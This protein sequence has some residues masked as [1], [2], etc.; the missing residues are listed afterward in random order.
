MLSSVQQSLDQWHAVVV[1]IRQI[2]LAWISV[3]LFVIELIDEKV[4]GSFGF[5]QP[6]CSMRV[7]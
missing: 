2:A 7:L 5:R 3:S 4:L 6:G 1:S